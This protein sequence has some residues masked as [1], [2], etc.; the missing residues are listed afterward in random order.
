MKGTRM[1]GHLY[2]I[3]LFLLFGT[4][5]LIFAM[6]YV[7]A[8]VQAWSRGRSESAY[9]ELAEKAAAAQSESAATL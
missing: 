8:A 3:T 5:V 4:P 2:L 1:S 6:K 9:R 7:S